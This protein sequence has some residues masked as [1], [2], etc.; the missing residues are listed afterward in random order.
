LKGSVSSYGISNIRGDRLSEFDHAANLLGIPPLQLISNYYGLAQQAC[1]PWPG[2]YQ[3][4]ISGLKWLQKHK[5]PLLCWSALAQGWFAHCRMSSHFLPVYET[6]INRTRRALAQELAQKKGVTALQIA[7][8]HTLSAPF[9]I[10]ASVGPRSIKELEE[11]ID[12]T[13]L[14]LSKEDC[15][16]LTSLS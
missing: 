15:V 10:L 12:A 7:L 9:R 11:I 6:D 1:S 16:F 4:E 3:L 2:A 8:S 5:R 14:T 13:S